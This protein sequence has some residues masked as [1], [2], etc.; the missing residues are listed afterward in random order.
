MAENDRSAGMFVMYG[1]PSNG[2]VDLRTYGLHVEGMVPYTLHHVIADIGK[3]P[4]PTEVQFDQ[5]TSTG[6][7]VGARRRVP[8]HDVIASL[9]HFV[10]EKVAELSGASR[11]PTRPQDAGKGPSRG[12]TDSGA[13]LGVKERDR[14]VDTNT[15][16]RRRLIAP[17]GIPHRSDRSDVNNLPRVPRDF[18]LCVPLKK[19]STVRESYTYT[20]LPMALERPMCPPRF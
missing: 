13:E 11:T 16:L 17:T 19:T 18:T 14:Q 4:Q 8:S 10:P 1:V 6:S 5:T 9:R 12:G 15:V 20:V 3:Q 2:A 7:E